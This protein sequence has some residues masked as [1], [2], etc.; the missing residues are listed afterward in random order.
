VF[1][2]A[3]PDC[4]S[5]SGQLIGHPWSRSQATASVHGNWL[6]HCNHSPQGPALFSILLSIGPGHVLSPEISIKS[7]DHHNPALRQ[8]ASCDSRHTDNYT[9]CALALSLLFHELALL[10]VVFKSVSRIAATNLF[11]THDA[12]LEAKRVHFLYNGFETGI[13]SPEASRSLGS[14]KISNDSPA[15]RTHFSGAHE[16]GAGVAVMPM[17]RT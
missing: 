17:L 7:R 9:A 10:S 15:G 12:C 11:L 2:G 16:G 5:L 3:R 13:R 6:H 4:N 14:C 1:E 8:T